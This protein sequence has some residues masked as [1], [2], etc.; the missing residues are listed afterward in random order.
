ML[1]DWR[2][3]GTQTR[4]PSRRGREEDVGD[5]EEIGGGEG[6]EVETSL[7]AQSATSKPC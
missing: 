1:R 7:D 2:M 5:V 6:G 4:V 3:I